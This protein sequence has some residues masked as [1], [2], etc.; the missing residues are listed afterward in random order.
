MA[1][2]DCRMA[3]IVLRGSRLPMFGRP[4]RPTAGAVS[5]G[6]GRTLAG[7]G[8]FAFSYQVFERMIEPWAS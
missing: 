6:A 7:A 3:G 1:E 2:I 5:G 8:R 4:N